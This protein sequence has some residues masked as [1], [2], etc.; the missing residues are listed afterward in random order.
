MA[1]KRKIIIDFDFVNNTINAE[2]DGYDGN[3]CSLDINAIMKEIGVVTSRKMKRP[4]KK[5]NVFRVQRN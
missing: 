3:T 5:K 2:A 4:T 1:K